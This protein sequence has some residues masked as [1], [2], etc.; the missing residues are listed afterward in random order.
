MMSVDEVFDSVIA[1]K[2]FYE[3]SGGGVTMSGG[4]PLLQPAFVRALFDRLQAESVHTCIETSGCTDARALLEVLPATDYVLYD[5]KHM[6]SAEHRRNTGRPNE[7][8][9]ENAKIVAYCGKDFLFRMPLIPGVNDH[10]ENI[11][12]TAAFLK[13]LGRKAERIELMP[14]HRLGESKYASIGRSHHL[15][16]SPPASAQQVERAKQTFKTYGI[17]CSVSR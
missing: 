7:L 15:H 6:D 9:L 3:P 2:M 13:G 10:V 17:E 8:I 4:E 11:E 16:D 14:Y 5:L 12:A 1:D